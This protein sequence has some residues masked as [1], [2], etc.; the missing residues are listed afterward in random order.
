MLIIVHFNNVF[1][2]YDTITG[3]PI[4][5]K[6]FDDEELRRLFPDESF[7]NI[8]A[9]VIEQSKLFLED[10]GLTEKDKL[11]QCIKGN[12]SGKNE[13]ELKVENFIKRFLTL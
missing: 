4:F 5:L 9:S 8:A 1:N 11:T 12:R 6:G 10:S 3:C 7:G 13:N 2:V